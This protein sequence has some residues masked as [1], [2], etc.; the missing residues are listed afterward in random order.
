[1]AA[2]ARRF[3]ASAAIAFRRFHLL[4]HRRKLFAEGRPVRLGGRA[5]DM[6][7]ALMR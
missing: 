5:F 1:M 6:L 4:P 7:M 2:D 3:R